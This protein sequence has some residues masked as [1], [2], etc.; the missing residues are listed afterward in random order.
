MENS[1]LWEAYNS[2]GNIERRAFGRWVRSPFFN[3]Q[4]RAT[5]LFD[6][7]EECLAKGKTPEKEEAYRCVFPGEAGFDGVPLRLATSELYKQLEHY[8]TYEELFKNEGNCHAALAAAYRRR[9]L[10]RHF[11][12][13][14]GHARERRAKQSHRHAEH[15][16]GAFEVEFEHYKQASAG[17]RTASLNIQELSDLEDTAFIARKLRLTC[18]ALSHQA[19]Y[20]AQYDLGMLEPVLEQVRRRQLTDT[21]AIGL[22]YFGYYLMARPEEAENFARF[23]ALLLS[24]AEQLPPD[25]RRDLYLIAINF[26]IKK[27]NALQENYYREAL[28]LY[29]FALQN[30]LL[31][32]NG[33]LSPFAFNNIVAIALKVR[34]TDWAEHF[35]LDNARFLEKK[36]RLA[37]SSLNLARVEYVRR[38]FKKALLHLQVADYKDL[39]NNLISKTLQLKIF[40]ES[41]DL[42]L[43]DAHLNALHTYIRRQRVMG[44]H[45]TNYLN[46]VKH[47][48]ALLNLPPGDEQE[49]QRLRERI[50]SEETLTEKDWLLKMLG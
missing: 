45:R 18:I 13:T 20:P 8:F 14:I 42:D 31:V 35:I 50:E 34:E 29:K 39:I 26:C 2:L 40:F 41:G 7:L 23:K 22:Y 43:V 10:E 36:Q 25:E 46:V 38:D 1:R 9:G 33:N 48:R 47:A 44:Y 28:D 5:A 30:Q 15:F 19:V 32:E 12:K 16:S 37:T 21:P 17:R 24:Q 27:V 6:Y 49:R 4:D 3:R 11:E